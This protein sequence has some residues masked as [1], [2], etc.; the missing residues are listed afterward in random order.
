MILLERA[1]RQHWTRLNNT[2][3]IDARWVRGINSTA[4]RV[5]PANTTTDIEGGGSVVYTQRSQDFFTTR[6]QFVLNGTTE[7][8]QAED[9]IEA[10]GWV[11]ETLPLD[12]ERHF[13]PAGNY[14][15]LIRIHTRPIRK[16]TT[17]P[18]MVYDRNNQFVHDRNNQ[19][20]YT[21]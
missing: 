18:V 20:V 21:E 5:V 14:N 2:A 16:I 1:E 11:W 7:E 4:I 10:L 8:L 17:L 15:Y 3:G 9:R 6:D 12:G 13:D 19:F